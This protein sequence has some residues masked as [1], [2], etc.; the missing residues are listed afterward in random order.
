MSL[1][2]PTKLDDPILLGHIMRILCIGQV[3]FAVVEFSLYFIWVEDKSDIHGITLAVAGATTILFSIEGFY[4]VYN[5]DTFLSII[6]ILYIILRILVCGWEI[7]D[8]FV[9]QMWT[10]FWAVPA[11]TILF[12]LICLYVG[13]RFLRRLLAEDVTMIKIS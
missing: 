3:V 12:R 7:A 1:K 8:V 13:I 6:F 10:I 11:V 2:Q 4:A 9:N 5:F